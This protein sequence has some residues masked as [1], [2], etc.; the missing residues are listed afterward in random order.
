MRFNVPCKTFYNAVAAVSKVINAKNSLNILDNFRI[1]LSGDQLT[2]TGA[3]MDN[4]LTARITVTDAEGDF[5]FCVAARRLVELLKEL[6]DQGISFSINE[7]TY[8]VE[9][10]YEGGKYDLT[11]MSG[12]EYPS[13]RADDDDNSEPVEF[14]IESKALLQ[15]LEYT[16]FAVG[17]DDYRPMM[18]GVF[19]HLFEDHITFVATDTHKLVR[20][21]DTRVAPGAEGSCI[22]P[23]KPATVL[24]NVFTKESVLTFA[25]SRKSAV[26]SNENFT[27]KC[28][29]LNGRFP[30]YTRVIPKSSPFTMSLD[31]MP[32]LNAMR[33]VAVFVDPSYGLEKFRITPD[34]LYIKS[35]D[36]NMCTCARENIA[37]S[38]NG[39]EMVIGFSAPFLIEFMSVLPTE[40]VLVDLADP[41]RPGVFRPSENE[42][43]T[44]LVMLL[45]PMNVDKF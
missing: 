5:C 34:R 15:G 3:D 9:I 6:P 19:F 24:R 33:R 14:T 38:F 1:N 20:Y 7:S 32:A 25:M 13:F 4:E 2:I 10:K 21:T 29:F 8:E 41:S 43:G 28:T 39:P 23:V 35:D 27:F 26:I 30:D 40:E 36:S 18:K 16:I 45:M 17:D 11:A 44:D 42:E 22:M 37:C 31:R 12:E